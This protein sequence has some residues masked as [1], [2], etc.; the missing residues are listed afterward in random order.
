MRLGPNASDVSAN[1]AN[2]AKNTPTAMR[3]TTVR[4]LLTFFRAPGQVG[5]PPTM[6]I[7]ALLG[8][9]RRALRS[10]HVAM[11]LC[12]P[13]KFALVRL[14]PIR[15]PFGTR[16]GCCAKGESGLL[17]MLHISR[18][19]G[20]SAKRYAANLASWEMGGLSAPRRLTACHFPR[21]RGS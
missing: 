14:A 6:K 8:F 10:A 4:G 7:A 5:C 3:E 1:Y 15:H 21:T 17:L 20:A 13:E 19:C 9:S 11:N 2:S 16:G 18:A 12:E